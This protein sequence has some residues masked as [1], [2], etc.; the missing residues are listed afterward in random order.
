MTLFAAA[1]YILML[2]FIVL[3]ACGCSVL[4]IDGALHLIDHYLNPPMLF[5]CLLPTG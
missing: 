5:A 4:V 3:M 2:E 1:S